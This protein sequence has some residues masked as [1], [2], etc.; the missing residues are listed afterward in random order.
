MSGIAEILVHSGIKVTG[1]DASDS[2]AVEKL[3]N[4]GIDV[5]IGHD[6]V[7]SKKADLIVYTAAV[8]QDD[9]ELVQAKMFNIPT[10]VRADFLGQLTKLYKNTICISGTH[11]KTTTTSMVSVCF[12]EAN[13]DPTIQV[14]AT[15]KQINGNYRIG[16]NDY[17]IIEACEYVESFLKFF[18]KAEIILNI[19]NDHL[20]YFK[21][22]ENIKKSFAKYVTLLPDDGCLVVNGDDKNCEGLA[23]NTN[24]KVITYGLKNP[25]VNFYAKNL[26]ADSNG[27]YQFDVYHN[28]E[29]FDTI[30]LSIPG[31]H[32]VSNALGC[33]AMCNHYGISKDAIKNGLYKFTGA[34]RRFDYVGSYK[35][36]KIYDDY[37]HHPT[38]IMSIANAVKN[39]TY[40]ESWAIF[41]SHT[42]SRTKELLDDFAN[43]LRNFDHVVITDIYAARETNQFG[44]TP[45][46]LV[47]KINEHGNKAIYIGPFEDIAKYVRENIKENDIVL[48]IG[49][50]TIT[51][52]GRMIIE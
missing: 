5:K 26:V 49:A 51:K 13:L 41:Q 24:A 44:I 31:A 12:L 23:D 35:G 33:I 42:Y 52:L 47:D 45:Q 15:L 32:N 25:N 19:D 6:L 21:N 43:V 50:G 40:N 46:D 4:I 10:M 48:T 16:K 28:G 17:F 20:D 34:D 38:E 11:G 18:P 37:A 8:K 2:D 7:N 27:F 14:G 30:K 9:P 36:V 1:S 3:I 29:F 22:I 39:R